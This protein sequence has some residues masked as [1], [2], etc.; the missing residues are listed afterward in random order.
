MSDLPLGTWIRFVVW[1]ALGLVIYFLY[2]Y[3]NSR[4]RRERRAG[5]PATGDAAPGPGRAGDPRTTR[6]P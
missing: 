2:G 1:L 6:P 5:A 4:L 3:R